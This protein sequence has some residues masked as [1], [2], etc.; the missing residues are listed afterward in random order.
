MAKLFATINSTKEAI[1]LERATPSAPWTP[2]GEDAA[3]LVRTGPS[4]FSLVRN[5]RSHR[6]LVLKEDRENNTVRLR[7]GAHTF[8]VQLEDDR[9]RLMHTLGLDKAT[10]KVKEVKAPMPGLVL[11]ILVK[12]GDAVKKN[13]PI[14]VLEAMKME[15][16]IKAP[17]DAIIGSVHAEKGKAVEK[18]QLL[19]S[20][21]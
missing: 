4:S 16:L 12:A 7:I 20:F 3:D 10:A 6:I 9:S 19:V 1:V 11:N 5:G 18:G 2:A 13:D 17:G 21:G 8:T 14:L 15:N